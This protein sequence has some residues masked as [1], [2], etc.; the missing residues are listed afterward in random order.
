MVCARS[1][2]RLA[3]TPWKH[4]AVAAGLHLKEL[5]I[6]SLLVHQRLVAALLRDTPAIE[7]DHMVC[8]AHGGD[9]A[10][11]EED[12]HRASSRASRIRRTNV[13]PEEH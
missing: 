7:H 2:N 6:K 10:E 3:S 12:L 8:D 4:V 1:Q 9:A 13:P 11:G 5:R